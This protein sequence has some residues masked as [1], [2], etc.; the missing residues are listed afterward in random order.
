[1]LSEQGTQL[2]ELKLS[3]TKYSRRL[4]RARI[5]GGI[6]WGVAAFEAILI[7]IFYFFFVRGR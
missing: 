2:D 5:S 3:L 6:G 1:M 7:T 4:K